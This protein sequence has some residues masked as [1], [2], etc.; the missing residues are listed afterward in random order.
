VPLAIELSPAGSADADGDRLRYSWRVAAPGRTPQTSALEQPRVT[1][2]QPGVYTATLTV[3]DPS[4]ATDTASTDI[5]A[6][7]TPPAV[8]LEATGFNQTFFQ[9]GAPVKYAVKV[10]DKE[11][12]AIVSERVVVSI[13]HVSDTFDDRPLTE[14][15]NPVDATTKFAAAKALIAT[16]DC[17]ACHQREIRAIGPS[18]VMLAERYRPDAQTLSTLANKVRLG[19]SKVWG[20]VEMPPHPTLPLNDIKTIVNYMLSVNDTSVRAFP[21]EGSATPVPEGDTSRGRVVLRATYT[22]NPVGALPAHTS[23]AVKVLRSMQIVPASAEI[24]KDVT[25]GSRSSG[26]GAQ[27]RST[28][29][30]A[31]RNGHIGFKALDLTGVQSLIVSASTSGDM[32]AA[33]GTLE[34]RID[35]PAGPVI[36]QADFAVVPPAP[37]GR[38]AGAAGTTVPGAGRGGGGTPIALR[39][40]PGL[41]DLYLVFR[42]DRAVAG[43]PL[44][45]VSQIRVN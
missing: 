25:F 22:D 20:D 2:S 24:V 32:R 34:V 28:A 44:M 16:T 12:A 5:V 26:G 18:F 23:T 39:A 33:G 11:N 7:N 15:R 21:L 30:T 29:I 36:G 43:Q 17:A 6:G 31:L 3:T 10:S 8:T 38:G 4:G 19:G 13:D 14:D 37:R 35:G 1:L 41:H 45:T 42:N 40:T 9:P 27:T